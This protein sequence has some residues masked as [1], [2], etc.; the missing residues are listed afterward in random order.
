[1]VGKNE[2]TMTAYYWYFILVIIYSVTSLTL[3]FFPQPSKYILLSVLVQFFV[4]LIWFVLNLILLLKFVRIGF[5]KLYWILPIYY[6]IS[7]I[8]GAVGGIFI[9]Y[10]YGFTDPG[11]TIPRLRSVLI[12][13]SI[14]EAVLTMG[15]A[16]YVLITKKAP[17][18]SR[19]KA[20]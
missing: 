7:F 18:T 17:I 4:A 11:L 15:F 1:M 14:T 3:D 20:T 5:T 16:S 6:V 10:D 13:W 12:Y 19:T 2:K 9:G 8:L